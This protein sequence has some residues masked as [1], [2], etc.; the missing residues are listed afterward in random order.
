MNL[1]SPKGLMLHGEVG[2]GKSMLIDLFA[3]CLPTQK[4][5][6]WHFNNFMLNIFAKLDKLR[7]SS[8]DYGVTEPTT[9]VKDEYPLLV[10]ARDLVQKS[11]ILFLDE[12]QLPDRAASKIMSNLMAS[13][14][15]LGGVLIATSNRMPD[16]LARAAGVEFA[17]PP[18]RLESLR[19]RL[20]LN[21]TRLGKSE[22]MF[23]GLGEFAAFLELL[24]ARCDVWEMEGRKDYRRSGHDAAKR[25]SQVEEDDQD[26]PVIYPAASPDPPANINL[27][28]EQHDINMSAAEEVEAGTDR[29][30]MP[31]HYFV[32]P[33]ATDSEA[34]LARWTETLKLVQK[35]AT[36]VPVGTAEDVPWCATSLRVY[37]RTVNV[38]RHLSG[39]AC[40]TFD[41]L[42][43]KELGPA[44][45][46]SL[47]S[48]FHTFVLL[49]VPVLTSS[50]KN[51]ARRFITLLDAL[52][53]ARC[54][55]LI[56]AASGPDDIFFPERRNAKQA[57]DRSSPD[58]KQLDEDAVYLETFS[59]V[60]Q[61]AT[62]PFRPNI[63]RYESVGP[64]SSL[65][66]DALEDDPPNRAH[67]DRSS[68][69]RLDEARVGPD[70]SRSGSFV[71]ED[72]LFAYRRAR[73]RLW[74]MCGMRWWQR[75]GDDWWLPVPKEERI[76][77]RS[78]RD[79]HQHRHIG[80]AGQGS[81]ESKRASLDEGFVKGAS[82]FRRS[83]EPPPKIDWAHIW[84]TVKWGKRA[85]AW[86]QGPEGL[87]HRK[88]ESN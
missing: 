86:G 50:H 33:S 46:I 74:E 26:E 17:P 66:E 18:A 4:K 88:K 69:D 39:V 42:C 75:Q 40:F 14:F 32:K 83:S 36:N 68:A 85:G 24:K 56:T 2:T 49:D 72:E 45:Y 31:M 9:A 43:G 67:R 3:E 64:G 21:E 47:A 71:G 11:P 6:R 70:F 8:S 12:F 1:D 52:F 65:A 60:Y 76:W 82:P 59:E 77:E 80:S 16:E 10:V 53:E 87:S 55:L 20:G 34:S 29:S 41:E 19:W 15:H 5:R 35:A 81:L 23:A 57:L 7:H 58:L 51:E 37:G 22:N 28:G 48:T 79:D 54:K 61:D 62:A 38:P 44:D 13:F 25:K 73:S 30:S 78:L 84:G 27:T 63:S